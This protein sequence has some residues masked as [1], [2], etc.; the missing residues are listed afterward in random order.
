[1][2]S[3]IRLFMDI[4]NRFNLFSVYICDRLQINKGFYAILQVEELFCNNKFFYFM[5][6]YA[7]DFNE[8]HARVQ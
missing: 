5:I 6:T 2:V 4:R 3:S 7:G 8:I 1:M